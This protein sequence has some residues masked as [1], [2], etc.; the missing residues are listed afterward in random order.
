MRILIYGLNFFPELAGI[1]KYSG[2]MAQ[3]LASRDHDVRVVTTPPYY[4]EWRVFLGHNT[5]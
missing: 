3:W 5:N 4:P 2:E 1:G